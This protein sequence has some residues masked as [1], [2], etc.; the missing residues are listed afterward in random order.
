M[1]N[2]TQSAHTTEEAGLFSSL[3]ASLPT[4]TDIIEA[5]ASLAVA[6]VMTASINLML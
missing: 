5:S 6:L 4:V 1:T 3:L 2:L